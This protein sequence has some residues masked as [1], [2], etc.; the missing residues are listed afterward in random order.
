MLTPRHL[1]IVLSLVLALCLANI[2]DLILEL[3][4]FRLNLHEYLSFLED[5]LLVTHSD[6]HASV[7]DL[8]SRLVLDVHCVAEHH[9]SKD[10]VEDRLLLHLE[11][12]GVD[13]VK[14]VALRV[15]G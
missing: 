2:V 12:V 6:E 13:L 14:E 3:K 11:S 1:L 10:G 4:A 8:D 15:H 9:V 7:F 5:A